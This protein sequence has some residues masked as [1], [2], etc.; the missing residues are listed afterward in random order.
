MVLPELE[1]NH[2]KYMNKLVLRGNSIDD[3]GLLE[4][5]DCLY[6]AH[7]TK[8][9]HLDLSETNIGDRGLQ[10]LIECIREAIFSINFV[11][12]EGLREVS[13]EMKGKLEACLRH[14]TVQY[15]EWK[16]QDR[17]NDMRK[18]ADRSQRIT[19]CSHVLFCSHARIAHC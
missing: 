13:Q 14:A 15:G 17:L 12:I 8:L 19:M 1:I 16:K 3:D 7:N 18:A 9:R 5:V 4:L 2:F 10:G 6:S 11:E